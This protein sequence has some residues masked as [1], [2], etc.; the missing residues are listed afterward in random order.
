MCDVVTKI[1]LLFV[2]VMTVKPSRRNRK[3]G[4]D[5]LSSIADGALRVA[6]SDR[7]DIRLAFY[8]L[9]FAYLPSWA[10]AL[11]TKIQSLTRVAELGTFMI[12]WLL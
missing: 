7:L 8:V 1:V 3:S 10:L 5:K 6:N 2:V 12:C 9:S 4:V 11:C